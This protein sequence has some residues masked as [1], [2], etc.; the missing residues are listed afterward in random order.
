ML[1]VADLNDLRSGRTRG[2]RF[3]LAALAVGSV[4][5]GNPVAARLACVLDVGVRL[6]FGDLCCLVGV[7]A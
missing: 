2:H 5:S 7:N 6:K 1:L 3:E 4:E